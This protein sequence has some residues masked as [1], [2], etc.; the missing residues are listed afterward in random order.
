M[1]DG[2]IS[3]T[4]FMLYRIMLFMIT[5]FIFY[6]IAKMLYG[7]MEDLYNNKVDEIARERYER[8]KH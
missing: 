6:A 8:S 1:I 2:T 4:V 7:P 3:F 5:L